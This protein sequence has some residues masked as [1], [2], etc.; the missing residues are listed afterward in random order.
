VRDQLADLDRQ[1]EELAG[2][3]KS[4]GGGVSD[5]ALANIRA[6]RQSV[7]R[8]LGRVANATAE[9]WEEIR[10]G[11]DEAVENLTEAVERAFPK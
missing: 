3:A 11:V 10:G 6:S 4:A 8:S 5:R 7:D 2:Q 9:N 1:I